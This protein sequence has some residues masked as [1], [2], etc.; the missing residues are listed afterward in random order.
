MRF[1][2]VLKIRHLLLIHTLGSELSLRR[3]AEILRTS[4]SA[5][6]RGLAEIE[7]QLGK[8]LFVRT[9]RSI[10]PTPA[11]LSLI[12]HAQRILGDLERAEADFN[13][14][15]RG[16]TQGLHV[17]VLSGFSPVLLAKAIAEFGK[18]LPHVELRLHEGLADQLFVNL[19]QDRVNMILSHVDVPRSNANMAVQVLYQ[20]RVAV[21]ARKGHPLTERR[22]L[23]M[24]DLVN[25]RWVLPPLGTTIRIALERELL[26]HATRRL[27]PIVES[28][29]PHFTAA[30][31]KHSN[32][33]AAVPREV[34]HW[35]EHDCAV[36]T[37]LKIES[38]LP[39]WPVCVVR[40]TL[41]PPS[42]AESGFL[43]CLLAAVPDKP[44]ARPGQ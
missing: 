42:P 9:T 21:V 6:S 32:L 31:L 18:R 38:A 20:E 11:G 16:A 17:G 44:P 8:K 7:A 2:R 33:I 25:Q 12:W 4:Q 15:A 22:P 37:E 36:A 5:V 41:R 26:L 14:L 40:T 34:A 28:V 3:S 39:S 10:S 23:R 35:L 29:G 19:T 1:Q 43:D 13:A 30:V 24:A 27:P